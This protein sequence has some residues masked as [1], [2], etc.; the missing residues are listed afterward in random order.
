MRTCGISWANKYS[1]SKG[2]NR[3][4]KSN[5][6]CLGFVQQIQ[7]RVDVKIVLPTAPTTLLQHCDH[8]DAELRLWHLD[9]FKGTRKM[10]RPKENTRI[11]FRPTKTRMMENM[12][13]L[14]TGAQ[15]M[16]QQR[17][18]IQTQIAIRTVTSPA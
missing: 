16:K 17:V 13:K 2:N 8:A 11:K 10:T 18:A 5:Q 4:Q 12:K 14:T 15:M 7:T 1:S 9:F 3:D 6:S